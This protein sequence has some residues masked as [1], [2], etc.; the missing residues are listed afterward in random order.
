MVKK[1]FMFIFLAVVF[2]GI[3]NARTITFGITNVTVKDDYYTISQWAKYLEKKTGYKIKLKITKTYDEM[4]YF[5]ENK[6]VDIA[7]IC[8]A[9]YV[10]LKK[11]NVNVKL[12]AVPYFR[13]KPQ[14]YSY[15]IVSK[16]SKA[17]SFL[18]LE[19]KRFAFSD[20]K[21]NSGSIAPSYYLYKK[22]FFYKNFF[23]EIIYTYSHAESIEAV[24]YGFVD[25]ASVDSLVFENMK[26]INPDIISKVKVIQKL[27]PFPTTPI[28]VN[29]TISKTEVNK[30]RKA[31]FNMKNDKEGKIILSRLG[32][33]YFGSAEGLDYSVI[34]HMI[35]TLKRVNRIFKK[36]D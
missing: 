3:S 25:G 20:P 12:L 17:K 2:I 14:Y 21:S 27:G 28:V 30:L 9:T 22:G 1:F 8:G 10:F 15:I 6:S 32:V 19:G 31:F 35:D 18:D 34:E 36:N 33:D 7:Y 13:E 26:R 29:D 16:T 24:A 11:D 23:K 4:Q 5:I